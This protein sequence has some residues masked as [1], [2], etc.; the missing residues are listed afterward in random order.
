MTGDVQASGTTYTKHATIQVIGNDDLVY[1]QTRGVCTGTGTA[2]DPYVFNGYDING[3]G[4]AC[5]YIAQITAH[6]VISNCYLHD[7]KYGVELVGSPNVT[8]TNNNCSGNTPYGIFLYYTSNDTVTNNVCID[9]AHG[10]YT[11]GSSDNLFNNNTCK[12]TN[13]CAVMIAGDPT[14]RNSLRNVLTNNT[15]YSSGDNGIYLMHSDHSIIAKNTLL[16]NKGHGI[17]LADSNYNNVYGNAL[18]GNNKSTSVYNVL[19]QQC[20]DTS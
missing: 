1:Y 11:I 19:H 7:N 10:I 16:N 15:C 4:V 14:P 13:A 3:T 6:V 9:S 12:A 8:I 18:I 5:I 17:H 2:S 20:A